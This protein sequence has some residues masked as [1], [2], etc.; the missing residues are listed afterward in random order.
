[1]G[2]KT[3]KPVANNGQYTQKFI[4]DEQWIENKY[5]G[6]GKIS[7]RRWRNPKKT[8]CPG[9]EG[10]CSPAALT[11]LKD[12]LLKEISATTNLR[13]KGKRTN[14]LTFLDAWK[15]EQQRRAEN[16]E[17]RQNK[18]QK[19]SC[20]VPEA[21]AAAPPPYVTASASTPKQT[22]KDAAV[23]NPYGSV[24]ADLAKM[25]L[26]HAPEADIGEDHVGREI[27][28]DPPSPPGVFPLISSPNPRYGQP[29]GPMGHQDAHPT[30]LVFRPWSHEDR[31]NV[32]KDVP[33]L[34]DGFDTW[35][36]AVEAIRTQWYLN[37]HEMYQ[38][39]QDLLGLK[40]G[41]VKGSF[42]GG[43][44]NNPL[45]SLVVGNGPQPLRA[46]DPELEGQ[47]HNF[48]E[49]VKLQLAPKPNY[50]KIG[51]VKQ[52]ENE[53]ASDF[54]DR[55]RPVFRQHSG[56]DYADGD[57][58]PFQQQLK[59]AFLNGL[60]PPIRAHVEKHW[61]TMN[62]GNLPDALLHAEHATKVHKQK[63]KA[64]VFTIDSETGFLAFSGGYQRQKGKQGN[65]QQGRRHRNRDS[66]YERDNACFNC[67]KRG[68]FERE[69]R[70]KPQTHNS[71]RNNDRQNSGESME[72]SDM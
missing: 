24:Q 37:G 16:R 12:S 51:E 66:R 72:N 27:W 49:R 61:V 6:A 2:N 65:R 38:V 54:L 69:C 62:T 41:S 23:N 8:S 19:Q 31:K 35:K 64:D 1:M 43:A 29:I 57:A 60:L 18:K 30:I 45:D 53:T 47:L 63:N 55:L 52:K 56:L 34:H 48:Y 13:K 68:H 21:T 70:S 10:T 5:P 11:Q 20:E 46:G 67:G 28:P 40:F 25:S 58:T 59:N 7:A 14:E 9:W 32:L 3:S 36:R 44:I 17:K 26:T 4:N 15:K 42:T 50:N 33:P 22:D 71:R 39:L